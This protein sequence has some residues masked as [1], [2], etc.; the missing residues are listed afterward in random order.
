MK[1]EENF[2]SLRRFAYYLDG[3]S[4]SYLLLFGGLS[5]NTSKRISERKV[6]AAKKY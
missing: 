5:I 4:G 3:Y 1:E 6:A 2:F